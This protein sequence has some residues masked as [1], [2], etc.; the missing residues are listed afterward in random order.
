MNKTKEI[1]NKLN[2]KYDWYTHEPIYTYQD[3]I[4]IDQKLGLIG[5]ETKNLFL[6]DTNNNYYVFVTTSDVRF[7]YKLIKGLIGIKLK[8]TSSDE[9]KNKTGYTA[10]SAATFPYDN[11]VIYLIDNNIFKTNH[12][13]CSG[14]L[15]TESYQMCTKDL[16]KILDSLQNKKIYLNLPTI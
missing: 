16:K 2:I 13:I 10:G 5:T 1:L 14:G 15:A 9:L 6:K 4:R 7:D 11:D 3:A 8:I 12:L